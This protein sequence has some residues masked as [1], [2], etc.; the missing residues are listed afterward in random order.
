M[1]DYI[2]DAKMEAVLRKLRVNAPWWKIKETY[3]N[4]ENIYKPDAHPTISQEAFQHLA[5]VF[6][7]KNR[8]ADKCRGELMHWLKLH[9][10]FYNDDLKVVYD[11]M[12]EK[13]DELVTM[14]RNMGMDNIIEYINWMP[15]YGGFIFAPGRAR[16]QDQFHKDGNVPY[17]FG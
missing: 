10:E 6:H 9:A 16:E 17:A 1:T 8:T 15:Q 7:F 4:W 12:V 11:R 2:D 13:R 14:Q 3:E 5:T